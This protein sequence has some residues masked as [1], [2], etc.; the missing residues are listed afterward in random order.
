MEL[1]EYDRA[2]DRGYWDAVPLTKTNFDRTGVDPPNHK[3]LDDIKPA[4]GACH[5]HY[6]N[7]TDASIL[8]I[9]TL[10]DKQLRRFTLA[11]NETGFLRVGTV[12]DGDKLIV[13]AIVPQRLAPA[14]G[15]VIG[16]NG[17]DITMGLI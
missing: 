1:F 4:S 2:N 6:T 3:Y 10:G 7:G 8:A 5:V 13:T 16:S 12:A 17:I 15:S 11:A 14:D 9:R